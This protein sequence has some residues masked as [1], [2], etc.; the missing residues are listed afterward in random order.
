LPKNLGNYEEKEVIIGRGRF[1]PYVKFDEKFVSIPREEDPLKV[2]MK[3]AV[4]LI[5]AK[6]K[7]DAPEGEYDG[8]PYTRGKGRFGPFLKWKDYFINI[9]KR[10]NPEMLS[11]EEAHTL[12]KAKIEK[13]RIATFI[14]GKMNSNF[15]FKTH[16]GDQKS[17]TVKRDTNSSI[18]PRASA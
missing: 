8:L 9:P 13:R 10:Y 17:S 1:G 7:E 14:I 15:L 12:I 6:R 2:T 18:R 16:V 3:R 5:E 4:E 11:T